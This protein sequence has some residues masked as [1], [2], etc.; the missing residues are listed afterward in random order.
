MVVRHGGLAVARA[1]ETR[2]DS[3]LVRL[4]ISGLLL[5]LFACLVVHRRRIDI[6]RRESTAARLRRG[7]PGTGQVRG[8]ANVC[9][10]G[11]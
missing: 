11:P 3:V 5:A 10:Q 8:E 4:A 9:A 6:D 2:P 7:Q 1:R